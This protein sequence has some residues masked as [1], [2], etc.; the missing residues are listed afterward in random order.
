MVIST[1]VI[2]DFNYGNNALFPNCR[3]LPLHSR[4]SPFSDTTELLMAPPP[5]AH[6]IKNWESLLQAH[7][8]KQFKEYILFGIQKGFKVGFSW[9][10]PLSPVKRN[11]SL[12][13]L[14]HRWWM[15]TSQRNWQPIT[16][17][18]H[19]SHQIW[20]MAK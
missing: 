8:D 12:A 3:P 1:N 7:P 18:V 10:Q 6:F 20:V 4:S 16:L 17:L 5:V 11:M 19:S 14:T 9:S 13:M 2:T 15:N